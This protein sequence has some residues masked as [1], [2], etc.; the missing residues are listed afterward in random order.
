[1][2]TLMALLKTLTTSW[3]IHHLKKKGSKTIC[4]KLYESIIAIDSETR[5]IDWF[6]DVQPRERVK[7]KLRDILMLIYQ[8]VMTKK[9]LILNLT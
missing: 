2:P 3:L 7:S 6:K 8:K 1:M 5:I 4:Q 9:Y